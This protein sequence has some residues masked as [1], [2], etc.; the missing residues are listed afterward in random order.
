[1]KAPNFAYV[2]PASLKH[3][4]DLLSTHAGSA[5][6][7]AGGQS[8]IATLNLRL[9]APQILVDISELDELKGI[10]MDDGVIHIGAG[11]IFAQVASSPFV[12]RHLPLIAEALRHVAHVAIRNRGTIGGSLAYADPAAEIPACSVALDATFVLAGEK[13]ERRVAAADFYRGLFET[14]LR[15]GELLVAARFPAQ[16]AGH[17]WG[18]CELARRH[19]DFALA[20]LAATAEQERDTITSARVVYFGCTDRARLAR[21]TAERIRG[22]RLPLSDPQQ[23]SHDIAADLAPTDSPGLRAATKVKLA[24]VLTVRTFAALRSVD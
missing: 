4:L 14:D 18:F 19:G 9:S 8:L 21:R 15:V 12:R 1:M 22:A 16:Q 6:P 3:A 7:L 17:K 11:T 10:R 20:G 23:L 24:C 2:K 5:I 13:G